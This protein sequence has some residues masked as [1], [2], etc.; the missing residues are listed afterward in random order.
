M[1]T[2]NVSM[3]A[4]LAEVLRSGASDLHLS[5]GFPPAFRRDGRL[6]MAAQISPLTAEDLWRYAES[7]LSPRQLEDIRRDK[8][9]DFSFGYTPPTGEGARFRGNC[10]Y[11]R[12]NLTMALR[13]ITSRIRTLKQLDMPPLLTEVAQKPRGLFLATGPT[14]SGKSTTLA[15][16]IQEINMNRRCHVVTVEDPIEYL[17]TS[18]RAIIHQREVGFDTPSFSEALRRVLR[19]DPDVIMI[20]EMRDLET[21]GAAVT[22][23]ETGHLVLSTV[24]TPDAAQSIDRIVDVFPAH[25]QNQVRLQ[26]SNILIG[27][28]SQQLIPLPGGGRLCATELLYATPA[29]RNCIREGKVSQLKS[30]LQTSLAQG[31]HTM[32]QDL[33][34]H[35]REGRIALE[36]ALNYASDPRDLE[37]LVFDM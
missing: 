22:A 15:A 3:Q 33:A 19:Q 26:L 10:Y 37:R 30:I 35:V 21:V 1:G 28:C 24:H 23:A 20:G 7:I 32:D 14:G 29:V 27:L 8:D 16:I 31:M 6:H 36:E 2:P 5:V 17:F 4:L 34:R 12:S 11:E 9:L 13:T 25:Q 18:E